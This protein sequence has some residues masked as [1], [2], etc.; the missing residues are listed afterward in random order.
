MFESFLSF[1]LVLFTPKLSKVYLGT[2]DP[3]FTIDA[4][5]IKRYIIYIIILFTITF[6]MNIPRARRYCIDKQTGESRS[7]GLSNGASKGLLTSIVSIF[8]LILLTR[9]FPIINFATSLVSSFIMDGYVI[10]E[11]IVLSLL[12]LIVYSSIAYPI[13]GSC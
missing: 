12:Y 3:G 7:W 8:F 10:A 4:A 9:V 2:V 1:L 5:L 11:G 13:W 6:L